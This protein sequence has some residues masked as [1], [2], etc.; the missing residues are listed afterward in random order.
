[1]NILIVSCSLN[2]DSHS[3]V[4]AH[5]AQSHLATLGHDSVFVDLAKYDLPLCDG[6]ACY[7]HQEVI[8][9][10]KQVEQ[11]D[12]ILVASPVYNFDVNAAAR[13]F[14][15]LTG[16]GWKDKV[17]GFI[18]AAGGEGSY[19]AVMP[20]A[21]SLM[22]DYRCVIIPRFVYATGASFSNHDI[23]DKDLLDRINQLADELIRFTSALGKSDDG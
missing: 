16:Q 6:G 10:A 11:A 9:L 21:N 2:P 3:A 1:M 4:I 17:V 12:G 8:A 20:F 5:A 19:M 14:L 7:G 23:T 22:L 13:N 15:E 18:L